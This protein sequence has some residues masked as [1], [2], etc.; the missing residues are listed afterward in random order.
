MAAV[1]CNFVYDITTNNL[2][3]KY[4]KFHSQAPKNFQ[5]NTKEVPNS[6]YTIYHNR[7][8]YWPQG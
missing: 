1:L 7:F 4:L 6:Y 8:S 2:W 5:D 3:Y